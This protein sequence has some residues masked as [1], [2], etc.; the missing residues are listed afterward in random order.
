MKNCEKWFLQN[1]CSELTNTK[2][3]F[4]RTEILYIT[5]LKYLFLI[6]ETMKK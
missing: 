5:N 1:G 2:V 6:D 3:N 4:N